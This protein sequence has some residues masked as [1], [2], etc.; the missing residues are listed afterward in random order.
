[1]SKLREAVAK[2]NPPEK[3]PTGW[4]TAEEWAKEEGLSRQ[5]AYHLL[6]VANAEMRRFRIKTNRGLY[7]VPHYKL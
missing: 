2:A 5:Q 1:M 3:V 6:R 4:K 7:P